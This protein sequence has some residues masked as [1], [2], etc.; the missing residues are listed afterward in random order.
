MLSLYHSLLAQHP[1]QLTPVKCAEQTIVQLHRY[2]EDVVLE[3]KLAAL[4]VEGLPCAP[5]RP[6]RELMRARAIGRAAR[7]A[8]F[9]LD[10]DDAFHHLPLRESDYDREP[11]LIK[12]TAHD[13]LEERFVVIADSRFSGVLASVRN[14]RASEADAGDEVIWTF[15]PDIVYSALEYLMARVMAERPFQ[16]PLFS[17]AVRACMP[18]ATSLQLTVAVTTKLARLLQEQA[19]REIAINRIATAIRSSLELDS[20]LQTTVNEVGRALGV[21]CCALRVEEE[22]HN[23]ALTKIYFRGGDR[24][25][26]DEVEI[27]GDLSAYCARFANNL[28]NYVVDGRDESLSSEPSFHPFA[29]VPLIYGERVIGALMVQS[30]DPS[31]IWQENELLLL[32]TVADQVAVAVNHARLFERVQKQ[33]LTDELTG[34]VNRRSFEMQLDRDIHLAMRMRQP[35]SLVMLDIDHFKR[36]NDTF[37]H[38]VGDRVLRTLADV[39]RDELRGVDTAARLGGEEF[40]LILPQADTQGALTVAE[41]IRKR[42]ERIE[43]PDVG[44]ITASFGVATF[45]RHTISREKLIEIADQALYS[46]KR[47]GRNRIGTPP[48]ED[49]SSTAEAFAELESQLPKSDLQPPATPLEGERTESEAES[50]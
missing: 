20:V 46:A 24:A 3:N 9:F 2:F 21:R 17:S 18:K 26:A 23:A 49:F 48:D 11:M 43:I 10:P 34:C 35:L 38:K 28:Q 40:A 47:A 14:R 33:A 19:G 4:V 16:A 50:P 32:R 27:Y 37:G 30:D 39:L 22:H 6:L 45:P 5:E 44:H 25:E 12:H 42:I 41:R 31:R 29:V 15:E 8:F 36:I 1:R 13:D 7:Y